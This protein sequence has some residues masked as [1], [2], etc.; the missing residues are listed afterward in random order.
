MVCM[1]AA[2]VAGHRSGDNREKFANILDK[3]APYIFLPFFTLTGASLDLSKVTNALP[4][5]ASIAAVRMFSIFAATGFDASSAHMWRWLAWVQRSIYSSC[6]RIL[7]R[8][9]DKD[10]VTKRAITVVTVMMT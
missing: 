1:I 8:A 2:S 4:L 10:K 9:A 7:A 3:A 6:R 5:A